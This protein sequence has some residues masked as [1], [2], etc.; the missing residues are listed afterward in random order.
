[1]SA[2]RIVSG[3]PTVA[4]ADA[5]AAA[6]VGEQFDNV[7]RAGARE[8]TLRYEGVGAQLRP[9]KGLQYLSTL[10]ASPGREI[11]VAELAGVEVVGDAGEVLDDHARAAYQRRVADLQAERA[12]AAEFGDLDRVARAEDEIDFIARELSA[13]FGLGGRARKAADTGERAR[14]AVTNRIKD[15]ITKIESVHPTL[16]RHLANAVR[17][18]TFCSYEP[19]RPVDWLL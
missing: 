6:E 4:A 17:T 16:G 18:G 12:E 1:V 9:S 3:E 2:W 19:E 11:H 13:A 5:P 15:A 7:F 10:L 8:W 14:K